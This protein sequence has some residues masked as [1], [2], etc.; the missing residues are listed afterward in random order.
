[1]RRA[2]RL[3]LG[4]SLSAAA[5]LPAQGPLASGTPSRGALRIDTIWSQS[6]GITKRLYLYLPPSYAR[7]TLRRHPVLFYLHGVG[8][9][10][11]N[12]VRLARLD[13]VMDSLAA[14]GLGEAI[15]AMPD[16][17]DSW[18]TTWHTLPDV[19]ACR[20]DTVRVEP[21]DRYCVPWPHYDDYVARD[22]VAHVDA[23]YRTRAAARHRGIAGLSMGGYGA[24]TLALRYPDVFTA[25][26]SH[27]GVLA[28]ALLGPRPFREPAQWARTPAELR[29]A[30]G[31]ER[32]ERWFAPRFGRDTIGWYARDPG[33]LAHRLSG[34]AGTHPPPAL[35][36]D[37]GRED[38]Y[39]DQNRAFAATLRTLGW[40]HDYAEP[41]GGHTWDYWRAQLPGSL[42]WLLTR[43]HADTAPATTAPAGGMPPGAAPVRERSTR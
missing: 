30:A 1:M 2:A 12:W 14:A 5:L 8:G 39:L 7:D 42:A 37:S 16:G 22:L 21:A 17:D 32:F 28:P 40:A 24:V 26:A 34:S 15:V 13:R 41:A 3:L 31:E 20:A 43:V 10:E 29:Q 19:A 25:A 23:T 36:F 18:Y 38:P 6:L 9:D 27:S 35:R 33:R 4:L 11:E